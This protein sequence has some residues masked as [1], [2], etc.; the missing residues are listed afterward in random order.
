MSIKIF[1]STDP[2]EDFGSQPSFC[3]IKWGLTDG[4]PQVSPFYAGFFVKFD[5]LIAEHFNYILSMATL[6]VQ[7]VFTDFSRSFL[8]QKTFKYFSLRNV[9]LTFDRK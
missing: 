6:V 7:K 1:Y 3:N 2:S 9:L 8:F 5:E 4:D